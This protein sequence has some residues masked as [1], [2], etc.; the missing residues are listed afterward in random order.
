MLWQCGTPQPTSVTG[1]VS[2]YIKVPVRK[3]AIGVMPIVGFI[4]VLGERLSIQGMQSRTYVSLPCLLLLWDQNKIENVASVF[5]FVSLYI[6]IY[7]L[8][9]SIQKKTHFPAHP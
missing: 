8:F 9:F 2:R 6:Y 4:E 3:V 1:T 7:I 5:L